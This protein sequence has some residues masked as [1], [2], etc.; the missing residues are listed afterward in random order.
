MEIISS[1]VVHTYR[2][3]DHLRTD[4]KGDPRKLDIKESFTILNEEIDRD[5]VMK[6]LRPHYKVVKRKSGWQEFWYDNL[7][8]APP[9]VVIHRISKENEINIPNKSY[10]LVTLVKG[11]K[12]QILYK[13]VTHDVGFLQSILIP[14]SV[15]SFEIINSTS[16]EIEVLQITT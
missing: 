2:F 15:T 11:E 6:N 12:M 10:H 8:D 14:A 4:E 1:P 9:E 13:N 3:Y 5:Y 7:V 16:H